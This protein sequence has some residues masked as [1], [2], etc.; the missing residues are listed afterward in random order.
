MS[1]SNLVPLP[2]HWANSHRVDATGKVR[3]I[4]VLPFAWNMTDLVFLPLGFGSDP[5]LQGIAMAE[6]IKGMQGAGVQACAKYVFSGKRILCS[7]LC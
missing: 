6:T 4:G 5:Y 7:E 2:E 3:I 1:T